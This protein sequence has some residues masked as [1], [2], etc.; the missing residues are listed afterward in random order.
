MPTLSLAAGEARAEIA[1]KGAETRTWTIGGR[2]LLWRSDPAFWA[3]TAPI[4]FPVVGW[5]AGGRIR[6]G[7]TFYPL[8]LHGF[9][10][11]A[12]FV[13]ASREPACVRLDLVSNEATRA[14]YPFDFCL[15]VE[16]R[17]R[18]TSLMSSL[19]LA[20]RGAVPMPYACG[21][22]PGFCWPFSGGN[23]TDY[24]VRF[25][26]PEPPF[27]PQIS[28]A[29][30]FLPGRRPVP[31]S[32]TVMPLAPDLFAKEALCFLSAKSRVLRF[33]HTSGAAISVEAENFPHFAL[34]SRPG[35]AFL[36]IETWTGH[37]D[38]E[39]FDGDLYGKPSMLILPPGG[40]ARHAAKYV[41]TA[42]V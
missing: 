41:F 17:L 5:T 33:E 22:H 1:L 10:R 32:G 13:V 21:L 18:E 26:H 27:V 37:G 19:T 7:E 4:L 25:E 6:V 15:S 28:K 39:D 9:A 40:E 42:A 29:G 20:N 34:W 38:R 36:S 12:D 35:A 8:G 16:H 2:P 31:L 30:L 14:L 24:C 23:M 11:H 3:D